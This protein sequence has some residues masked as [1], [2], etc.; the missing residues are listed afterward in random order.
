MHD[1][2]CFSYEEEQHKQT[3]ASVGNRAEVKDDLTASEISNKELGK[4]GEAAAERFLRSKGYE[5]LERNW[6]CFA[7]E[8]DIIAQFDDVL[9]FIEVKTRRGIRKGFPEEAVDAKKRARY[10]K[11]AACYLQQN[12]FNEMRVRFDVI[13]LM[14][15]SDSR[16][17]LRFHT[18]AF[19]VGF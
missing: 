7:G 11:I 5:V 4:R 16:A 10:E 6:S 19:G 15:V 14:V 18:N 2:Y 17:F 13:A 8:V 3:E 9:C 1:E 12:D